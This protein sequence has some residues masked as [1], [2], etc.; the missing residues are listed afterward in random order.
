MTDFSPSGLATAIGSMPNIDAGESL[1]VVLKYLPDIPVW[2]QLPKRSFLEN[3]YVQYS[4]GF[5]GVVVDDENE[6]I[7]VDCSES[8]D[9]QLESLYQ[10]Y[11]DNDIDKY[12]LKG[13]YAAGFD[14]FLRS[15]AGSPVAVKGQVIGP[16]SWG[17]AV[18]DQNRRSVI[19]DDVLAD[20]VS[21]HL[22]LKVAWQESQL[23][24]IC[25][26]TVVFLDEPYLT[27]LGSAFVAIS[28]EK[29]KEMLEEVLSGISGLSGIHCCGVT[30][31]SLLLST[32]IDIL[33]FDAYNY[34]QSLS[35]FADDV[36]AFINRGGI[37]GWGIV[38]SNEDAL[39]IETEESLMSRLDEAFLLLTGKG[40]ALDDLL[41]SC[42]ITPSCGLA[43]I[44][45]EAAYAALEMTNGI[46]YL[47]KR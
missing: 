23:R 21:K 12:P 34:A 14:A 4:E 5:P 19:Y 39:R 26:N 11:I 44:S 37:I 18:T 31:W 8:L 22:R 35:L 38:P 25:E 36:K 32:S 1:D 7:Y 24:K 46:S 6:R 20:A 45:K 43:S 33:S 16:V 9:N 28:N 13:G 17:L 27:S 3:M 29:V 40:I 15:G 47:L 30:D 2:P 41:K 10:A 42:L